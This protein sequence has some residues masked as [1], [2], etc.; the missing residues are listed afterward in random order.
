MAFLCESRQGKA[1]RVRRKQSGQV[2][3]RKRSRF[4]D[5]RSWRHAGGGCAICNVFRQNARTSENKKHGQQKVMWVK[6]PGQ[7]RLAVDMELT[8]H[9]KLKGIKSNYYFGWV[10]HLVNEYQAIWSPLVAPC[11]QWTRTQ[12]M[13]LKGVLLLDC[14][15]YDWFSAQKIVQILG[16]ML[17]SCSYTDM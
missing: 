15:S 12:G 17:L 4:R 1:S 10:F 3:A 11:G 6:I 14:C 5:W 7:N 16:C 9:V 2:E 8:D 13:R